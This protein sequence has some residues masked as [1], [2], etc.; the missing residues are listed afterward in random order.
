MNKELE[1]EIRNW[2]RVNDEL[3]FVE[4]RL[5]NLLSDVIN[6]HF[7]T[8]CES[9]FSP[10]KDNIQ[11]RIEFPNYRGSFAVSKLIEIQNEVGADEIEVCVPH[12]SPVCLVF[13]LHILPPF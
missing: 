2:K 12:S 10:E 3:S 1:N 4:S 5:G 9:F 7:Q 6:K 13:N 11:C 8:T